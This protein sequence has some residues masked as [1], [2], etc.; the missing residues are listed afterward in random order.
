MPIR[1]TPAKGTEG[2]MASVFIWHDS[3]HQDRVGARLVIWRFAFGPEYNDREFCEIA[4]GIFSR[5]RIESYIF[6][7]VLGDYDVIARFW[8]PRDA[9]V[10]DLEADFDYELNRLG[11]VAQ[12][13]LRVRKV[14]SHWA[15]R[16][17]DVPTQSSLSLVTAKHAEDLDEY[18]RRVLE[19]VNINLET[20]PEIVP[21]WA[22]DFIGRH[23][24][25]EVP[26]GSS[27]IRFFIHMDFP[28]HGFRIS[29]EINSV[30]E[31]IDNAMERADQ[32][33]FDG[34][35]GSH[36]LYAGIG[37]LTNFFV[38]ARS[39][40]QAFYEYARSAVFGIRQ[41]NAIRSYR[42]RPYT[43]VAAIRDF[44]AFRE[45]PALGQLMSSIS[46]LLGQ[47]ESS[48]LELKGTLSVNVDRLLAEDARVPDA[49]REGDVVKAVCGLL[50]SSM[51]NGRLVIGALEFDRYRSKLDQLAA[52]GAVIAELDGSR[53]V[54]V[55][56]DGAVESSAPRVILLGL[57]FEA[58]NG[59]KFKNEDEMVRHL[60]SII[61]TRIKPNPIGSVSI[62]TDVI[63][64]KVITLVTVVPSRSHWYFGKGPEGR[65]EFYVRQNAG[66]K[67]LTPSE[68]TDYQRIF[69]RG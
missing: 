23:L 59:A 64:G 62:S 27:A 52:R 7:E 41:K 60:N 11:L 24:I 28:T 35:H 14:I 8:V 18:N 4:L 55:S 21:Q 39:P 69:R 43:H 50:N 58:A 48:D 36:S 3:V 26:L 10:D 6:Y 44:M 29:E 15:W 51:G 68:I 37:S 1:G 42:I 63:L 54:E 67:A 32:L 61:S 12:Q 40:D 2:A 20:S 9:H 38:I 49:A 30:G 19:R 33:S 46:D 13:Y 45:F 66:T 5:H 47:P 56:S 65:E 22:E 17:V 16:S 25:R 57:A 31:A 53:W 34:E